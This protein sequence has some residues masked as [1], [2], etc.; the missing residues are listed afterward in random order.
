VW[1]LE[2]EALPPRLVPYP[3]AHASPFLT[4]Q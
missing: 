2:P 4:V 3:A 1:L